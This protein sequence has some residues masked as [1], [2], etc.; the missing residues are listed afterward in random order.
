M[1]NVT[2]ALPNIGGTFCSTYLEKEHSILL[3][4][5]HMLYVYRVCQGVSSCVKDG[6]SSSSSLQWKSMDSING[7]S[8]YLN[9]C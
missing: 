8:Y 7:I 1:P 9:K 3:S 5:T 6:S 4:V 2:A